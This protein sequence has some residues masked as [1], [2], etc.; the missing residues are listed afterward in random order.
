MSATL[1]S[2]SNCFHYSVCGSA[3]IYNDVKLCKQFIKMND[4][5]AGPALVEFR[6]ELENAE[7]K[8]IA[9]EARGL[10]LMHENQDLKREVEL[11]RIIKQTLEMASGM[12]FDI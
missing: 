7:Q 2:C 6:K 9:L 12:K 8:A 4:I 3:S 11:L 10:M 5:L 1:D